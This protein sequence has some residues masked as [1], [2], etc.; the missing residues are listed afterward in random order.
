MGVQIGQAEKFAVLGVPMVRVVPDAGGVVV[1]VEKG[2]EARVV[3]LG[4]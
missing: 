3:I 4:V 2:V 1:E